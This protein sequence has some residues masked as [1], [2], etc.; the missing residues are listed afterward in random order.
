MPHLLEDRFALR[1]RRREW[2]RQEGSTQ[3]PRA[4]QRSTCQRL[5]G[6]FEQ[7]FPL[8][9]QRS[10]Q[11]PVQE[12]HAS[13]PVAWS[14]RALDRVPIQSCQ[15]SSPQKEGRTSKK[16]AVTYGM[17]ALILVLTPLREPWE[18]PPGHLWN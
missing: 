1:N 4:Q 11:C 14:T 9:K 3:E 13:A 12:F 8:L 18:G 6:V 17:V 10:G 15:P 7:S 2:F 16:K 5:C